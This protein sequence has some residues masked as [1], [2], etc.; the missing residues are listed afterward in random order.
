MAQKL[1][2]HVVARTQCALFEG[3]WRRLER[4]TRIELA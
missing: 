1:M 4:V 2:A 3:A